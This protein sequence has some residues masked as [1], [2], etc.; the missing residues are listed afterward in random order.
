MRAVLY[1]RHMGWMRLALSY[2]R[3]GA[4]L[5]V[6][7][8]IAAACL[9]LLRQMEFGPGLTLDSVTYVS[10][11]RNLF[12]GE[13]FVPFYGDYT[14]W[15]PL[16]S[17]IL[18]TIGIFHDD[19]IAAAAVMNAVAFGLTVFVTA[20]WL[21]RYEVTPLLVAWAGSAL[22]LS[23]AAGVAAYVWSESLFM[24]FVMTALYFLDRLLTTRTR[25]ALLVSAG[26]TALCCLTRYAGAS[27]LIYGIA[28]IAMRAPLGPT[29]RIRAAALYATIGFA[30]TAL[31][32]V[33]NLLTIGSVVG[34]RSVFQPY[35]GSTTFRMMVE[36]SLNSTV[37]P[38]VFNWIDTL[39]ALVTDNM[40]A[41]L[42]TQLAWL[43]AIWV[44]VACGFAYWCR[45]EL[46]LGAAVAGGFALCYF[47]FMSVASPLA[48]FTAELRYMVP[49]NAP[50]LIVLTLTFHACAHRHPP[51]WDGRRAVWHRWLVRPALAAALAL[52]L[53]QW[54]APNVA[55]IKQWAKHGSDGYGARRWVES[56]TLAHLK[57]GTFNDPLISNDPFAVYALANGGGPARYSGFPVGPHR[58]PL[59]INSDNL[60]RYSGNDLWGNSPPETRF[61][62]FHE[63]GYPKFKNLMA[64]LAIFPNM[65]LTA[66]YA[67]GVIFQQG[68]SDEN[69]DDVATQLA[70]ALLR[71]AQE[72]ERMAASRFDVYLDDARKRL[73]YV[74]RGC[75]PADVGPKFFLH[76]TPKDPAERRFVQWG[77][78]WRPSSVDFHNLDFG[79]ASN[80]VRVNGLCVATNALPSFDIA[81]IR[82]GQWSSASGKEIWSATFAVPP[83]TLR[84]DA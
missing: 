46:W 18:A 40:A 53:T 56:E 71:R 13:G 27:I 31:W 48:Q 73:T 78:Q 2:C 75:A 62:W 11:A 44:L 82:T 22:A 14:Y 43:L 66:T 45:K 79:F 37:G 63:S 76:V 12:A 69:A 19:M 15:A 8:G 54:V 80:G 41:T 9:V 35:S 68:G 39:S 30:P 10:T 34:D 57:S 58:L 32:M 81:E 77:D 7:L 61:V 25:R 28:L 84:R 55:E 38:K 65:K 29:R 6:A 67:D 5:P 72:G 52:W 47:A 20:I 24:L 51:G 21:R 23:P 59:L 74:R 42:G 17:L 49:I 16:F 1:F 26:L 36:T 60:A 3:G 83:A 70:A 33:Y 64:F 4:L 50:M